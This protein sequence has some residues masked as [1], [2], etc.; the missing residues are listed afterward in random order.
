[1]ASFSVTARVKSIGYALAG[2]AAILRSQHNAWIHLA[3]TIAAIAAGLWFS[4][5]TAEWIGLIFAVTVVWCAEALNT[6]FEHLCDLV[7]PEHH[8][9]VKDAKDI[10]AAAVLLAA[11][12]AAAVGVLVFGPRLVALFG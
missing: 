4:V 5:S 7:S 11:I 10:A 6:A 1:M 2:I 3:A 12:G 8:P 9:R